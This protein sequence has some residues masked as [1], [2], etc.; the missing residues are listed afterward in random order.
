MW[1][2]YSCRGAH[3][4]SGIQKLRLPVRYKYTVTKLVNTTDITTHRYTNYISSH[5]AK[6]S[7][8][9]KMPKIKGTRLNEIYTSC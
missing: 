1:V 4:S 7:P 5:S 8:Y 2:V 6:Y 9:E 3:N